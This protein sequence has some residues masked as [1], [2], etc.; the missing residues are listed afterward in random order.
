MADLVECLNEDQRWAD[1]G[2]EQLAGQACAA[3]LTYLGIDPDRFS[4]S[5]LGCDDDRI[6]L[7]NVN[8]REKSGATNVLS[9]P[10]VQPAP[11][12][13]GKVPAAPG[14]GVGGA[15]A[16][17]GDIAIAFETC[18]REAAK[19]GKQ[20]HHHVSHLLVHG[21]LHL[22]GYDHIVK[23]DAALMEET[24]RLVLASLGHPDPYWHG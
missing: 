24:E 17:L 23:E 9:W 6:A 4:I 15:V 16:E 8:F 18:E 19:A 3:T 22:L 14:R 1:L 11:R 21:T 20:L 5:L 10:A 13:A 12:T 2:L 7:L